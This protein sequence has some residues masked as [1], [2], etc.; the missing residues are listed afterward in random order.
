MAPPPAM[1]SRSN[2]PKSRVAMSVATTTVDL[3]SAAPASGEIA[4][5]TTGTSIDG[6]AG[7]SSARSWPKSAWR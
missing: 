7:A 4:I 5:S 3:P 1:T 6:P 2:G